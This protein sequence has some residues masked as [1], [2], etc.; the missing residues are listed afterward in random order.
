MVKNMLYDK[1]KIIMKSEYIKPTINTYSISL[2]QFIT[3]SVKGTGL[4][5]EFAYGGKDD[6]THEPS[7]KEFLVTTK[8]E[9]DEEEE[10]NYTSSWG[11][12]QE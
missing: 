2:I 10:D 9:F 6:G 4:T 7:A 11:L 8:E 12:W 5:E 1:S 3:N